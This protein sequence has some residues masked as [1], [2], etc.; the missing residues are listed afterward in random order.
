MLTMGSVSV[1]KKLMSLVIA[2]LCGSM[3]FLL[4]NFQYDCM[5]VPFNLLGFIFLIFLFPFCQPLL[6]LTQF[7]IYGILLV[8]FIYRNSIDHFSPNAAVFLCFYDSE[9]VV[10][11]GWALICF[12]FSLF[13]TQLLGRCLLSAQ[14]VR[15]RTTKKFS[16]IH[17]QIKASA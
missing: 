14:C 9:A 10:P 13:R 6:M 1:C 12:P 7:L 17:P 8:L 4:Q 3:F 11:E 16:F 5:I 2:R 15:F